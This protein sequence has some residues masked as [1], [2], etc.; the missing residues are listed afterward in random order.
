MGQAPRYPDPQLSPGAQ[1]CSKALGQAALFCCEAIAGAVLLENFNVQALID[2]ER[3]RS[4]PAEQSQLC[5]SVGESMRSC[6]H[7]KPLDLKYP[8]QLNQSGKLQAGVQHNYTSEA[9]LSPGGD[10]ISPA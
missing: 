9:N 5:P 7:N 10:Y 2:A 4:E 3:A 8:P 6:P 1:F